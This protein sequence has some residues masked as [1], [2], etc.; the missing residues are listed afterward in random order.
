MDMQIITGLIGEQGYLLMIV[1]IAIIYLVTF[2]NKKYILF[3]DK[4][5]IIGMRFR[6]S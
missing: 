1:K 3:C 2:I 5:R 6:V 4:H